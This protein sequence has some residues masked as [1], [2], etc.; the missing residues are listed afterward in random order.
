M[1]LYINEKRRIKSVFF[2]VL[3]SVV[4]FKTSKMLDNVKVSQIIIPPKGDSLRKNLICGSMPLG[5]RT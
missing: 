1:K 5:I 3:V 4:Y 2:I